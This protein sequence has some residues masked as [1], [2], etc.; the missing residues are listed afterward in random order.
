MRTSVFIV[1]ETSSPI[2]MAIFLFFAVRLTT[3]EASH[4]YHSALYKWLN[5]SAKQ[6]EICRA[7]GIAAINVKRGVKLYRQ[8][9]ITGFH[10]EP[11]RRGAAVLTPTV[12]VEV[13]RCLDRGEEELAET[14]TPGW[15]S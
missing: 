14:A 5:G 11:R 13:Q 8:K 7:F 3:T 9:G 2:F 15:I 1:R 10:Q 12:L 6:S 4:D